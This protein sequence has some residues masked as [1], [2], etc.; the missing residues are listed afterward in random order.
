MDTFDYVIVG[1]GSAGSVL[2]NRLTEDGT[3]SVLRAGGRAQR[4]AS[5]HPH[6]RRLHQ[7][8]SQ[9]ARELALHHGAQRVD[10]RTAHPGARAARRSAAPAPST[11]TSTTAASAW[12]STPGRRWATAAGA[13]PTC[14][15]ISG[16]WSGA[17]ATATRPTAAATAASPSPTST[18]AIPLCEAFIEGAVQPRHPAQPRLQRRHPGRRRL[19]PAHHQQRPPRQRRHRLPASRAQATEPDGAH[20]RALHVAGLRRQALRRR[21]LFRRRPRRLH[22]E[23]P[24]DARG[25]P[26]RRRLQLAPAPAAL[27]RRPGRALLKSLGIPVRHALAGVG[28]N[29]RDHYAPRFT[30]RVKNIDTINERARGLRLVREVDP[31]RDHAQGHPGAQPH[32]H[33]LLLALRARASPTSDLQLTFTPAS[34]REGVQG[35]LDLEPGMTIASWQQRPDSRGYVR[36]RSA[37]PFDAPIIQPNYLAEEGDRRVLLAGMKLARRLLKTEAARALLR[38]RG[39]PGR[40]GAERRRAARRRQAARHHHVPPRRHLPHGAQ[41]ATRWPS[42][43]ISCACTASKACAS[44]TPRSCRPCSRPTS[45]P[46]P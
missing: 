19:R 2:A 5:L 28:E 31:L 36:L 44:S 38:L 20:P 1:A 32:P 11:A 16:A 21:R 9:P 37:D 10:W 45:T 14:S 25:D 3:A 8:L 42:S 23:R 13:T 33:L 46:A 34:Y 15:P 6:P 26:L 4:L 41:D 39:L 43:T 27:G 12:T 18:G 7:D 40:Q 17:S 29:L 30:A 24:R 22:A 35:Q